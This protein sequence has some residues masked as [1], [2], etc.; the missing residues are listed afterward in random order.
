MQL[1]APWQAVKIRSLA[2]ELRGHASR[3]NQPE[4]Q[5]KFKR[6]AS[7]LDEMADR[8]ERSQFS[9]SSKSN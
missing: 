1:S 9:T 2:A 6:T 7:E 8:L 4:Y 5:D 3:T